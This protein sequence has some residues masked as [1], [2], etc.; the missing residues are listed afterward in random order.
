VPNAPI[1]TPGQNIGTS[2]GV[3]PAQLPDD[4]PPIA[5]NFEAPMR[6]LPT[7]ER[8]GVDVSNQLPMT[9]QEA[10]TLALQNNNDIDSS[11]IDVSIAEFNFARR[12]RRL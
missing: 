10:I 2:G 8:V 7:A 1:Q 11:K 6:P 12:A 5:P 9:L 3:A 4:P